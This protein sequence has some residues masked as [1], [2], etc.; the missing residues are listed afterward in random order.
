MNPYV[1]SQYTVQR[2]EFS[3]ITGKTAVLTEL[4]LFLQKSRNWPLKRKN[5]GIWDKSLENTRKCKIKNGKT[6]ELPSN[7][8]FHA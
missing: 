6:P 2:L 1:T 3:A 7:W 5:T 8:L 4:G